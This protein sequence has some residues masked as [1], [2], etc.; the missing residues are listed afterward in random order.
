MSAFDGNKDQ[1][2]YANTLRYLFEADAFVGVGGGEMPTMRKGEETHGNRTL[3][4]GAGAIVVVFLLG[5][6]AYAGGAFD[7]LL[8]NDHPNKENTQTYS[9]DHPTGPYS[10]VPQPVHAVDMGD[11][12]KVV[13][14]AVDAIKANDADAFGKLVSPDFMAQI[15]G[16]AGLNGF[17]QKQHDKMFEVK[18]AGD[19]LQINEALNEENH[20]YL[21]S[22]ISGRT[23]DANVVNLGNEFRIAEW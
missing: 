17:V 1:N 6:F 7:G 11:P 2:L 12:Y 20:F 21:T 3:A 10:Y 22:R 13:E 23:E 8:D 19:D 9:V 4:I 16:E 14:A 5:A 18:M 15:G